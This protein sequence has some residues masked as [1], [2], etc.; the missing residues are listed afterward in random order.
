MYPPSKL[1]ELDKDNR[2]YWPKTKEAWPKLKRYLNEAKGIPLQD[3]FDDIYSL[4]TM[5]GDK[6]ERLGY[7]TQKPHMRQLKEIRD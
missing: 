2:I 1:D 5:G 3:I 6:N 7:P 4:A